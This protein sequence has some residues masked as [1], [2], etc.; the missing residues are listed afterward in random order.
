MLAPVTTYGH[1]LRHRR[2][3]GEILVMELLDYAGLP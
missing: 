3:V 1:Q 2:F